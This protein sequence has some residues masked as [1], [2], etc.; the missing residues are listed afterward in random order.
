LAARDRVMML[1]EQCVCFS[2]LW[3]WTW[4]ISCTVIGSRHS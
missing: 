2:F 3:A 1:S 4:L